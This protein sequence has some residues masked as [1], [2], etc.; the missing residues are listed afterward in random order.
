MHKN[1]L[2][3]HYCALALKGRSSVCVI[4]G[5]NFQD[6]FKG[7]RRFT[8]FQTCDTCSVWPNAEKAVMIVGAWGR[9]GGG[10][11]AIGKGGCK[12]VRGTEKSGESK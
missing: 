10:G 5:R 7:S 3:A 2:D 4:L 9:V 8:W 6:N 11:V 12:G 1:R